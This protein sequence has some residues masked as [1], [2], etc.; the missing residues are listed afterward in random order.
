V[1]T[2]KPTLDVPA[3]RLRK[4]KYGSGHAYY[5]DGVK[6][7]S[8]TK[9]LGGIPKPALTEW[10][11]RSAADEAVGHW[12]ELSH[13][14]PRT[15]WEVISQAHRN[16][17]DMAA[18]R[19]TEVHRLAE[20]LSRHEEVPVPSLLEG[21]VRAAVAFLD[22]WQVEVI[23][24]EVSGCNTAFRYGGTFDILFRTRRLPG[25]I[26]L[27]DYKTNR[28]GIY[29]E[30]ALQLEAYG[31]FDFV[32]TEGGA[33][34]SLLELAGAEVTDHVAIHITSDGYHVYEMEQGEEPWELFQHGASIAR[35]MAGHRGETRLDLM[36]G[37]ELFVGAEA[38]A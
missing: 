31:R 7:D 21:H 13:M 4:R 35:A 22:E 10:A 15:R 14:P 20:K 8:V 37:R 24:L 9:L 32:T 3:G 5:L 1:T 25:R 2:R 12:E 23:A 19:G 6:L 17:R 33:E 27:G 26:F 16:V 36:K 34:L 18:N 30:T 28:T 11:A 29:G 38:V